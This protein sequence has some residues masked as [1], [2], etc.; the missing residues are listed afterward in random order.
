MADQPITTSIDDLV[1]YVHEHGETDSSALAV[2][3][4]VGEAIIEKW[5][6]VLEKAQIVKV[7]YKLGKMFVAPMLVNQEAVESASKTAELKRG[8]VES[9][10]AAQV[11]LVNQINSR[12]DEFKR[13]VGEAESAF[14]SKAG[15]IKSTIDEI[16]RLGAEADNAYK[17]VS[18][19]K[20]YMDKLGAN[21][22]A[23]LR[24]LQEKAAAAA[25][26][27]APQDSSKQMAD[28]LK[29]KLADYENR[30][31]ALDASF[32][33]TLKQKK[34]EFAELS[35]SI[36]GE[37]KTM[38]DMVDQEERAVKEYER[39]LESYRHDSEGM[40][41][42]AERERSRIM[43][44]MAKS[45]EEARKAYDISSR[46]SAE[47]RK[48]LDELKSRFGGYAELSDKLNDIK[49]NIES[50]SREKEEL[51]AELTQLSE[52]LRAISALGGSQAGDKSARV[53]QAEA[54]AAATSKKAQ[55]LAG[56][57]KDVRK[58]I[59][60]VAGK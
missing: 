32:G 24:S 34:Q 48:Q 37:Q 16:D 43:D 18:S 47:V 59:D 45:A 51:R 13:Y 38:H 27:G 60:G 49:S 7:S 53:E 17:K 9:E 42:Q 57:V 8:I 39:A 26:V 19:E 6:D 54:H 23:Q 50:I 20:E 52:Q 58:K 29:L 46:Q 41:K 55:K 33:A 28:D 22:D 11:D 5:A 12:L 35:D 25:A 36:R 14:K 4:S 31:K 3:L 40:R 1:K 21:M 15:T 10:L 56:D 30:L 44:D 2:A